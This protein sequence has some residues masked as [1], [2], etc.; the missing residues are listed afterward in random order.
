MKKAYI[1]LS[2]IAAIIVLIFLTSR[3]M[4]AKYITGILGDDNAVSS[5]ACSYPVRIAGDSMEPYFK[6]GQMA[7]FNKC[8]TDN[9]M[10]VNK[11]IA[12]KDRDV[13]RLGIINSIENLPEGVT[14]KV[15]Q[16]NRRD[17]ASDVLIS[18]IIAIYK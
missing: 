4:P 7:F 8:F 11:T 5:L 18:Q 3:F 17:R 1:I 14:Y 16:P 13:I 9:D 15:I 10:A 12:F 2:I 6:N